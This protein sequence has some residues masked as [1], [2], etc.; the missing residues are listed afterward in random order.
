MPFTL[1][2]LPRSNDVKVSIQW[3]VFC[4]NVMASLALE[5]LLETKHLCQKVS[6]DPTEMI[7]GV[8]A[9]TYFAQDKEAYAEWVKAIS[10]HLDWEPATKQRHDNNKNRDLFSA[11]IIE[12][13]KLYCAN[14]EEREAFA[15]VWFTD[16]F[17]LTT[18]GG[19]DA[20]PADFVAGKDLSM[21][22]IHY[23]C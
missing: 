9:A 23:Q 14:C 18:R 21:F 8:T 10:L 12:N 7:K 13:V 15:P 11:L 16:S 2:K 22:V 3:A 17:S 20:Y 1:P 19:T 6:I 5:E 4:H